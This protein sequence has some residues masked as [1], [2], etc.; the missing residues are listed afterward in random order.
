MESLWLSGRASERGIRKSEVR[1][2]MRTQNFSLSHACEKTKNIFLKTHLFQKL[3]SFKGTSFAICTSTRSRVIN[4]LFNNI[5]I[6]SFTEFS[7]Q[8][9]P[10]LFFT[11]IVLLNILFFP[12]GRE[13]FSVIC[14][15]PKKYRSIRL[16]LLT[17]VL[18]D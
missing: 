18:S 7:L 9:L 12:I 1:F 13:A 10:N 16:P 6:R 5:S 3:V 8:G 11:C 4:S 14:V 2:L 17:T 15:D